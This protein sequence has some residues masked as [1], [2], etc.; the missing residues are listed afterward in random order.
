MRRFA[1]ALLTAYWAMCLMLY[2]R[3]PARMPLHF[4]WRGEADG[5]TNNASAVWFML[6]VIATLTLLMIWGAGKL[7][8]RSPQ[9]WNVP[10]KQ[11]FLALSEAQRAPI[12][13][14]LLGVMDVAALYTLSLIIVVQVSMYRGALSEEAR[15]GWPFHLVLWGGL[16]ALLLY[17]I[18]LQ[19]DVRRMIRDAS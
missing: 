9:L 13:R 12:V 10:E 16:L 8:A 7:A 15:L 19:G 2:P 11:R 5:W 18:R 6:P 4:N 3:L 14:H 17:T 1:Y